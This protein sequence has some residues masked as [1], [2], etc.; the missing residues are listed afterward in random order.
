VV[1]SGGNGG[2]NP[3]HRLATDP[4]N[5]WVYSLFQTCNSNC[6]ADPKSIDYHLNRSTDQGVTWTLNG[7][8]TGIV[9]ANANST[10]PQPKFGGVNA[11]LGGVDH[12]A[13]D[14][15]NGDLY[16]V[17]G[18]RDAAGNNRLA[19]RRVTDNG[20]GGVNVGA[21]N[22]VVTGTVQAAL[23]QVSVNNRGTLAVFYYTFN[24]IVGGFPQFSTFLATSTNQG[25]TFTT[26]L[27]STFLSPVN[28]DGDPRQRVWGDYVQMKSL[29]DCFY[30]SFVANRAAFAGPP[31]PANPDPIFFKACSSQQFGTFNA[32]LTEYP[33]QPGF[34]IN[35]NFTLA[36]GSN[37]IN[38]PTEPVT[39]QIGNFSITIPP[40]SFVASVPGYFTFVGVVNGISLNVVIRLTSP[41]TFI[42]GVIARNVNLTT[43]NPPGPV[44]ITLTIGDDSGS[45][46]VTPIINNATP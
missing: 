16:Y 27:L 25:A 33:N 41:N 4:R 43:I 20:A 44:G 37:G 29:N 28:D 17:Y 1:G 42:F 10:Q 31:A 18:N 9:V 13:V 35:A 8:A 11:L 24:G 34:S 14:P 30:G 5:G 39:L 40:G 32:V 21:E 38:P 36:A 23:P 2:I 26:Q 7:S 12:A 45:T 6:G 22:F 3:G 15:T 19:I 46:T